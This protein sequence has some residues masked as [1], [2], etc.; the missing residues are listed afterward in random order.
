MRD[1]P[2]NSRFLKKNRLLQPAAFDDVFTD[3]G[4]LVEAH[5]VIL[6]RLNDCGFPRLGVVIPKKKLAKAVDRNAMKRLVRESFRQTL[7]NIK[8]FDII[9]LLRNDRDPLASSKEILRQE[10][11]TLWRKLS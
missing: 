11:E 1:S 4:K 5:W 3:P 6:F 7:S 9:V 8:S 10:L 2:R